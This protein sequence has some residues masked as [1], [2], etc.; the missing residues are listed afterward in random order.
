MSIVLGY[1]ESPGAARALR[2]AVEV[3]AAFEE[4]LVLVYG[5]A[6]P[7]PTGE[8]YRSHRD[9]IRQAGRTGLEHAVAEAD[10]AGVPT[11]VEVIDERPAQA[12]VDA[13]TRHAARVI[14]VGSWSE[15]PIRG[16]LLGSTPHK[17]LHMSTVPVL[18]VP[19]EE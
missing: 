17:L 7:G 4:T 11:V 14:V 13:A 1:D 8:E 18:C 5:A 12:L 15:S 10:R 16:A 2:I 19:P 9:A 3:A 6:A